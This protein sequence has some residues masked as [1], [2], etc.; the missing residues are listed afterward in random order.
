[1]AKK[2]TALTFKQRFNRKHGQPLNKANSIKDIA[3]KSKIKYKNALKIVDKGRG[4]FK[5][6]P[7]SVRPHIKS[8]TAWGVSRLYASVSPGSKSGKIDKNLLK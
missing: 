5:S 1:M 6:S 4:A 7:S 2:K 8:A 3:K